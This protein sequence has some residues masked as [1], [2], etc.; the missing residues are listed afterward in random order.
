VWIGRPDGTPNP[1]FFGANVAAPLL[2]DIV[3]FLP[4][5]HDLPP[6]TRP[7][8]VAAV[9]VCWPTGEHARELAP[10]M[11]HVKRSAWALA[12]GVP[13]T[14]PDRMRAG[15]LRETVWLDPDTGLRVTPTCASGALA[16]E[17]ARWPVNLEPWLDATL[18]R[19]HVLPR[20][21]PGCAAADPP[22]VG[23]RIAGLESGAVLRP[24]PQASRI[25]VTLAA[26]GGTQQVYWLI[27]GRHS[28]M[29]RGTAPVRVVF[30]EN[31]T[32][33]ITAFDAAGRHHR[34]EIVVKG[35]P[36]PA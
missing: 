26:I 1:G 23:L 36:P 16:Q 18:L 2:K 32:H 33:A 3:A 11:C 12:G 17:V 21:K 34:I 14:L 22:G 27:D 6:R 5:A 13:P 8:E 31:G 29:S 24:A 30:T 20:W 28:Q 25:A 19:Q 10:E 7:A 15:S 9:T 4:A 35:L